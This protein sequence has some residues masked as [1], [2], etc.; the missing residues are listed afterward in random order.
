MGPGSTTPSVLEPYIKRVNIARA[1]LRL[2]LNQDKAGSTVNSKAA[3]RACQ[4]LVLDAEARLEHA[5]QEFLADVSAEYPSA[6]DAREPDFISSDY[7]A[8]GIGFL[9]IVAFAVAGWTWL[10]Q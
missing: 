6:N 10:V 1:E 4:Q 7:V 8:A 2:R 9:V 3:I 5:K